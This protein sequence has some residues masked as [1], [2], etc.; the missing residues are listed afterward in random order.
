[1]HGLMLVIDF[2][3]SAHTFHRQV[4]LL[5]RGTFPPAFELEHPG[6]IRP[7]A[8]G[9]P[10]TPVIIHFMVIKDHEPRQAG[11]K[12]F[13]GGWGPGILVHRPVILEGDGWMIKTV[14]VRIIRVYLITKEDPKLQVFGLN[15]LVKFVHRLPAAWVGRK[16]TRSDGKIK[17]SL[18]AGFG[19]CCEGTEFSAGWRILREADRVV[20][21]RVR[22]ES[23]KGS[24]AG[25]AIL[26][27]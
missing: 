19:E 20:I 2:E 9:I 24:N 4:N 15:G 1:M 27:Q 10:P 13:H 18:R 8:R 5:G 25:I 12:S 22:G 3:S 17:R 7:L 23:I 6:I 26:L 14:P 16:V 21:F 11:K